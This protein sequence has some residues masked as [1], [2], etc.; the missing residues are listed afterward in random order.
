MCDDD[1]V[2]IMRRRNMMTRI[3]FIATAKIVGWAKMKMKRKG[4]R[5][6]ICGVV[7]KEEMMM[8]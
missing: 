1:I 3:H 7:Y 5:V 4:T 2:R 6:Y 8:I